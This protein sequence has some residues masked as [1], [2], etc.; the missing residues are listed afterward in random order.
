VLRLI[1]VGFL[2]LPNSWGCNSIVTEILLIPVMMSTKADKGNEN[3]IS[4]VELGVS[5]LFA[6]C[7]CRVS[8]DMYLVIASC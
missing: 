6:S 3:P 4:T 2:L 7:Y 5:F 1:D 8:C